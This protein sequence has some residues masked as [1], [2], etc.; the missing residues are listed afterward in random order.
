MKDEEKK[1]TKLFNQIMNEI[2]ENTEDSNSAV[3]TR[4]EKL[5]GQYQEFERLISAIVEQM[6]HISEED[7]KVMK[8]FL[9]G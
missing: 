4:I 3:E 6:T 2:R 9:N 5:S 7:I 8:G 1:R